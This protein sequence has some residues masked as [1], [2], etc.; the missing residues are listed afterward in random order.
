MAH[1]TIALAT[2]LRQLCC[3]FW[4]AGLVQ[5]GPQLMSDTRAGLLAPI[6]AR[7]DW[8]LAVRIH[9][10]AVTGAQVCAMG[11][12]RMLLWLVPGLASRALQ[13]EMRQ[14]R[15]ACWGICGKP[16]PPVRTLRQVGKA[17]LFP[18]DLHVVCSPDS[19]S[20]LRALWMASLS[21]PTR[22]SC[23]CRIIEEPG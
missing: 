21:P 3:D 17:S 6:A 18:A 16:L 13:A 15:K 11:D 5:P 2:E 7:E 23:R 10:S 12:A 22:N 1:W 14:A 8:L 9:G 4:G 19:L 20:A